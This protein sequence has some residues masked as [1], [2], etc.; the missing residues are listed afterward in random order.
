MATTARSA[1]ALSTSIDELTHTFGDATRR[2]VYLHVQTATDGV[3]A[4]EISRNFSIH[5]NVAR[6]HLEK[7]RNAGFVEVAPDQPLNRS[8]Q[9]AGR[10]SRRYVA[11]TKEVTVSLPHRDDRLLIDLLMAM[12]TTLDPKHASQLAE[13]AG[14]TYGAQLAKAQ[15]D[16]DSQPATTRNDILGAVAGV[17]TGQ[18]FDANV[19]PDT[20]GIVAHKC[21]FGEV[22]KAFPHVICA[23][24]KGMLAGLLE[25]LSG[26]P[27]ELH[28]TASRPQGDRECITQL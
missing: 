11:T 1:P 28:L 16:D 25:G 27:Q 8:G 19:H 5:S 3:T 2:E 10:P 6:H 15:Q 23:L 14:R 9:R 20:D 12:L 17:L 4:A 7:L 22:A 21:P 26:T 18:G 13:Q 24:D